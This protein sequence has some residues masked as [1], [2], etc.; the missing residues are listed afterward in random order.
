MPGQKSLLV[1]VAR[2]SFIAIALQLFLP[3]LLPNGPP[4]HIPLN[5]RPRPT[6]DR[7]NVSLRLASGKVT[8]IYERLHEGQ[9]PLLIGPETVVLDNRGVIHSMTEDSKLVTL[10]E[11]QPSESNPQIMTAKVTEVA[12]LGPGRALGGKF[13]KN[14]CLYFAD[15]LMGLARICIKKSKQQNAKVELIASSVQLEDGSWSDIVYADDVDIGPKTGHVYFSDASDIRVDRDIRS[16]KWDIMYA[17]KIEAMRGKM[18]GRI[19]RFKPETGQVDILATGAAFANG[20]AVDKDETFILY[21][22]TYEGAV[23]KYSLSGEKKGQAEKLL[24]QFPGF[25]DGADCS[26]EREACYVAIP[27][28]IS[29]LAGLVFSMP[30][31]IGKPIRS[32]LMIIPRWMTPKAEPYGGVAEIYPGSATSPASL[33]RIFQDPDGRDVNIITGVTEFRG[34]LYLGSLHE[35]CIAIYNL[36]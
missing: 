36:D 25:L 14:G 12:N 21:T 2:S 26:F 18:S 8:K 16:G 22:S 33:K 6:I 4:V 28:T 27:S 11:L 17:S 13:D 32:L 10:T 1:L 5:N 24:I 20:V 31:F 30:D 29:P 15:V 7:S 34:K 35:N 9:T 19:L 23:M 3:Y